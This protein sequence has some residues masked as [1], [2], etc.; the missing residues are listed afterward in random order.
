MKY[1]TSLE[2]ESA[3]WSVWYKRNIAKYTIPSAA[4]ER[5]LIVRAHQGDMKARDEL[6]VRNLR[7]VFKFAQKHFSRARLLT[8]F[9]D[10]VQAGNLGLIDAVDDFD[11]TR[12]STRF[13]T[14]AE[15]HVK[16]HFIRLTQQDQTVRIPA[17]IHNQIR[18]YLKAKESLTALSGREPTAGDVA[19]ELGITIK[20]AQRLE[21]L[22]WRAV[23][24]NDETGSFVYNLPSDTKT[25]LEIL[26]SR[27]AE[28]SMQV[29]LKE[30]KASAVSFLQEHV[31]AKGN[32]VAAAEVRA[33][34]NL[35]NPASASDKSAHIRKRIRTLFN[36]LG[37][38]KEHLFL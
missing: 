24:M 26:L 19:S 6:V 7:L 18:A 15:H 4:E 2:D 8:S 37:A 3:E 21:M 34:F 11:P 5:E 38:S 33:K 12:F 23:S 22:S 17:D 1:E 16:K 30:V 32:E 9:A 29:V 14:Y 25:P 35:K 10:I 27:E 13:S 36:K 28:N 20:K 31:A